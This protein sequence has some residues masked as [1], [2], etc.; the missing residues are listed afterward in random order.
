MIEIP[1]LFGP[2]LKA[3]RRASGLT[4]AQLA[5]LIGVNHTIIAKFEHGFYAPDTQVLCAMAAALNTSIDYL[6]G[7]SEQPPSLVVP[8]WLEPHLEKLSSLNAEGRAAVVALLTGLKCLS[9]QN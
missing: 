9:T 5:K 3:L 2:R 7:R 4:Q 1:E 8:L 6:T